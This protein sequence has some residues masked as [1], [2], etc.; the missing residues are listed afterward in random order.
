MFFG[1]GAVNQ[2]TFHESLNM[3]SLW[4]LPVIYLCEN[5]GYAVTVSVAQTHGQ[6]DIALRATG[7]GMP[8]VDVDGQDIRA[9]YEATAKAVKRARA[10]DGP[11]LIVANTYRFDKHNFGL[12]IPGKPYRSVEEIE[13][14]KRERDPIALYRC[15]LL[16][17]G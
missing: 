3:A 4:K 8:G 6:P 5:N 1:D 15:V 2:G 17:E 11:T 16:N 7:F 13:A 9:V 10:G 12:A 14:Y